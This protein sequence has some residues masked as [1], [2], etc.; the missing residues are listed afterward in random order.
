L[1]LAGDHPESYALMDFS[2]GV[3]AAR[4]R[5]CA[6]LATWWQLSRAPATS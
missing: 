5:D 4:R 2:A 6:L 3:F 1:K